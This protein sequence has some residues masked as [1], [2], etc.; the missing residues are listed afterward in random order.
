MIIEPK[1]FEYLVIQRSEVAHERK[2][3]EK[4]KTAYEASLGS[5]YNQIAPALPKVC[6]HIVDV[7]SGLGGID[8]LLRG[9]YGEGL[10][11]ISLIDGEND[12]PE[13]ICSY[14]TFNNAKVA[15]D[16]HLKNGAPPGL[17]DVVQTIPKE[18]VDLFVSFAAYGFHVH[19]GNYLDDIVAASHKDTV[20][21]FDVRR[22]KDVWLQ[23]FVEAFGT[24]RVLHRADKYVRLA[25]RGGQKS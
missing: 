22:T 1:H 18:K 25:F 10:E 8:V 23:L 11:K 3:F 15:K 17:V 19:P 20:L 24:P 21:I 6:R 7:G 2:N 16:F 14:K 4:W 12:L 13:V 9:H 5:I